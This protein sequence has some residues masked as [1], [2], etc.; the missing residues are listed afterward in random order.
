MSCSLSKSIVAAGGV[1][2][3]IAIS[4]AVGLR[5]LAT[6][7]PVTAGQR[8]LELP[9]SLAVFAHEPSEPLHQLEDELGAPLAEHERIA[10]LLL[11]RLTGPGA[12]PTPYVQSLPRHIDLPGPSWLW[13]EQELELLGSPR[14]KSRSIWR[15]SGA[16][17][18]ARALDLAWVPSGCGA[19]APTESE[20]EW[21]LATA[22]SRT[23]AATAA[24]GGETLS[25]LAP[26]CDMM[27]HDPRAEDAVQLVHE[28]DRLVLRALAPLAAGDAV[29]FRCKT[30]WAPHL[31]LL[32]SRV[33]LRFMEPTLLLC[34]RVLS[35]ALT[36][37]C[38]EPPALHSRAATETS[39]TRGSSCSM[40]SSFPTV[41]TL[42]RHSHARQ[43]RARRRD[44]R[45]TAA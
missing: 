15:R 22:T 16:R 12:L 30:I 24:D 6:T 34:R 43:P 40:D 23:L 2:G 36:R 8:L 31:G 4:H 27:N 35:P 3:P 39:R 26:L 11:Q 41:P 7:E 28:G 10:C 20:V 14:L 29:T 33:R 44:P 19:H 9:P 1:V 32:Q 38:K 18:L 5:G 21:A 37:P 45:V 13:N 17:R 25:V 42:T